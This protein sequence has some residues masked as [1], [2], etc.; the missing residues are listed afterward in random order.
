MIYRLDAILLMEINT[1][2]WRRD[3]YS[4]EDNLTI[5]R[6]DADLLEETREIVHIT[7][8]TVKQW[9]EHIYNSRI[10]PRAI[11]KY[12]LVIRRVTV[13]IIKWKLVPN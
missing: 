10:I 1:P 9:A 6:T 2:T 8:Y 5:L 3:N 13:Q 12:D 4:N 11:R 7:V